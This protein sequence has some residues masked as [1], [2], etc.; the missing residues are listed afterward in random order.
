MFW[1][2]KKTQPYEK[3]ENRKTGMKDFQYQHSQNIEFGVLIIENK[4]KASGKHISKDDSDND[5][6]KKKK[7]PV[8]QN[9]TIINMEMKMRMIK[10]MEYQK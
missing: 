10:Y 1:K 7:H 3:R 9:N 5:N 8:D 6:N 4:V 2:C